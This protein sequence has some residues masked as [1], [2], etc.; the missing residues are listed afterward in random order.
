[1]GVNFQELKV[2]LVRV[3]EQRFKDCKWVIWNCLDYINMRKL[4]ER[5]KVC[6]H[7][8]IVKTMIGGVGSKFQG[9]FIMALLD[10][11]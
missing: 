1:M 5:Q 4:V 7:T 2:L 11:E 10:V 8:R 3:E 9:D 6:N